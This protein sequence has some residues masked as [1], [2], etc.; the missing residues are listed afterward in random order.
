MDFNDNNCKSWSGEIENYNDP[1]QVRNCRLSG[2]PDLNIGSEYV[3]QQ[4]ADYMNRLIDI[5]IAGFRIDAVKH[6]W[7]GDLQGLYAKLK[8]AREE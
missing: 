2:L 4:I 7:P 1:V 8:N 5:G 3:K 6:M